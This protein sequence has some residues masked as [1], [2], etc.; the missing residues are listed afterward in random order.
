MDTRDVTVTVTDV[1][2][3]VTVEDPLLEEFDGNGNM[4]IDKD[5]VIQA[6]NDYLD[7][8]EGVTKQDVIDVIN[9]YLDS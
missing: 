1:D 6:I 7:S 2:D 8:V 3:V 9:L 5:E 4:M